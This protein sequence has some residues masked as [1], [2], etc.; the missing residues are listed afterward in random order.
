M[1]LSAQLGT[2]LDLGMTPRGHR[3]VVPILGG[4]I[5][6]PGLT[7]SILPGGADWQ[8]IRQGDWVEVEARYTA[9]LQAGQL[10][11]ILSSGARHGPP[12]VMA[13][14]LAGES[15]DP[16]EYRFRTAMHFETAEGTEFDWLNHIVAVA[17]AIRDPS[18]VTID[19][20]EVL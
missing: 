2:P 12:D 13:R 5:E 14:L 10:V 9:E 6:G 4:S 16:H 18:A 17:S 20:Y 7:G 3:R 8:L 1:R 19:V 15:P 11:S